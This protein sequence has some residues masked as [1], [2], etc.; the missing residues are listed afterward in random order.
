MAVL[1]LA[2]V[3]SAVGAW[4]VPGTILGM[5]GAGFGW[6]VGSMAGSLLFPP[7]APDGPRLEG[8][9]VQVSTYGQ[10]IPRVY[11]T[12]RM[13]GNVLWST[14]LI[15]TATE[16][17]GKGG[18]SYTTYSYRASF[19]VS[20][21]QGPIVGIRRIWADG[22]LIFDQSETNTGPQRDYN[23]QSLA[24]YV[25]DESQL[26]DPTIQA[27]QGD[28]P[29][30]RGQAYVVFTDLQLE[31]FGNRLPSL[32]FEVVQSGEYTN[33]TPVPIGNGNKDG[34]WDPDS[35]YFWT[36]NSSQTV[37]VHDVYAGTQK[38][39]F[40][41]IPGSSGTDSIDS[42][43]YSPAGVWTQSAFGL[44][45]QQD[46][47]FSSFLLGLGK[48]TLFGGIS[49]GA[50]YV[51]ANA[52]AYTQPGYLNNSAV[53]NY[54]GFYRN[55]VTGGFY[56][57]ESQSTVGSVIRSVGHLGP[58]GFPWTPNPYRNVDGTGGQYAY[59]IDVTDTSYAAAVLYDGVGGIGLDIIDLSNDSLSWSIFPSGLTDGDLYGAG[60]DSSRGNLLL[61]N[62]AGTLA[63]LTD[64]QT[65]I[66]QSIAVSNSLGNPVYHES[67]DAWLVTRN[68]GIVELDPVTLAIRRTISTTGYAPVR[69]YLAPDTDEFILATTAENVLLKIFV[70]RRLSSLPVPLSDVVTAESALVGLVPSDLD[71]SALTA[72]NVAGFAVTSQ[73][74]V[75]SGMEQLMMAYQFDAVESG[76]VVKFVRRGGAVVATLDD[77][78]L[79]AHQPGNDVPTPL[80]LTRAEEIELPQRITVRYHNPAADYQTGAQS[81]QRLTGRA[82]AQGGADLP[83]VLTDSEALRVAEAALYSAWTARLSTSFVT[84]HKHAALEPT[85]VIVAGGNTL[86]ITKRTENAG[87]ITF[88]A[89]FESGNVFTQ[90]ALGAASDIPLQTIPLRSRT[91][92]EFLDVPPLRDQDDDAGYYLAA[93]GYTSS[94][95]GALVFKS[96]DG[97]T[98][99]ELLLIPSAAA[100]GAA[101]D[102]LGSWNENTFDEQNSVT[103]VMRSGELASLSETAVLNGGNAA[104]LGSEILQFKSATLNGNG[105]YTLRGLLRGRKAT[106]TSGHAAGER[107]VLLNAS[108]LRRAPAVSSEVGLERSFKA[109]S[110]G[111]TLASASVK[112]FTNTA[113]SLEP[114]APAQ[115]GGGRS[116]AGDVLIT[117]L[118]RTRI[119]GAWRNYADVPLA[120]AS[121]SYEVDVFADSTYAVLKRTIASATTSITYTA[122]QQTTD[123]GSTQATVYCRVYQLSA[124]N[125][126]GS[127]LQGTV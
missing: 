127:A 77:A 92:L 47:I 28:T 4:A 18:P 91:A 38:I 11:G 39:A 37:Y 108:T 63:Y 22:K 7:K 106:P 82:M 59:I 105:S 71:V 43:T 45:D 50:A 10:P 117:W 73:G 96:G 114:L 93:S 87:L 100:V 36:H 120:E 123:F 8:K 110:I 113:Q 19:A 3:G 55:P 70:G 46:S 97:A 16:Q 33:A 49:Q 61:T 81:A 20:I 122:A 124:T 79:A 76:G 68:D 107:F 104:L 32:T 58:N 83:I 119:G 67:L 121:E 5:S 52:F 41:G 24:I 101:A 103:I 112:T 116:A 27:L 21:C 102:A 14:D 62:T 118:R 48:T 25:G 54:G 64:F 53:T 89:S 98:Y 35:G 15:E 60:Y 85:D 30:Y 69:L 17:D 1:A 90:S 75:R 78:D 84:T 126:R 115:L 94:W 6:M 95:D 65:R 44:P 29:A 42:I 31:K 57:Y 12:H 34:A 111:A 51:S 109:V 74:A 80:P 2:A 88:D 125:G 72:V 9:S 26:P 99:D 86:R 13:A 23:A 56:A 40:D 66:T